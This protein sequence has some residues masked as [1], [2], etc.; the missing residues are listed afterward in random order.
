MS[1]ERLTAVALVILTTTGMMLYSMYIQRAKPARSRAEREREKQDKITAKWYGAYYAVTVS[2]NENAP[3]GL[4]DLKSLPV[5]E[6]HKV[7]N[8]TREV[9]YACAVYSSTF[10]LELLMALMITYL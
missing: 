2:K 7:E 9:D 5:T 1:K 8:H 6:T 4:Y 10:T 3:T